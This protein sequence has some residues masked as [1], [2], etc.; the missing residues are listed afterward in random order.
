MKRA[1]W[2]YVLGAVATFLSF[3]FPPPLLMLLCAE[4]CVALMIWAGLW[5]GA[6][7]QLGSQIPA[8]R[9]AALALLIGAVSGAIVLAMLPLAG[10]QS[11]IIREA[12]IPLWKWLIIAFDSSVLEEI[13][14]RLFIVSLVVWL[15]ARFV[16]REP[17]IWIAI[18]IAAILFGAAHLN[19]W[20]DAGPVAITAVLIVNGL[21]AITFGVMYVRWGIEAAILGH[22]AGDV[23]VH[24]LGPH[25]FT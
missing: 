18:V 3:P 1:W 7:Y 13:I 17:A 19:R 4:V 25:F 5:F 9:R 20:M 22:F 8:P 24:I 14:F 23:V 16:K 10:L 2:L 11:R 12:S 15:L 6:K 21:I